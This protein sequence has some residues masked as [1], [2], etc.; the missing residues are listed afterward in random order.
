MELSSEDGRD[1]KG[2]DAVAEGLPVMSLDVGTNAWF[3]VGT[4]APHSLEGGKT[5]KVL[6]ELGNGDMEVAIVSLKMVTLR[7]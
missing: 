3:N 2:K 6:E 1:P 7:S 5:F 4:V